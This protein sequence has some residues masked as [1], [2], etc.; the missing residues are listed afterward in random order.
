MSA[1]GMESRMDKLITAVAKLSRG[2]E[3]KQGGGVPEGAFDTVGRLNQIVRT[4][5]KDDGT[6]ASFNG[7]CAAGPP[8]GRASLG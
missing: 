7:C 2:D 3:P 5:E 8:G 6:R 1:K 4:V